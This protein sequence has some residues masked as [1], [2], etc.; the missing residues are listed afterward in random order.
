MQFEDVS[1]QD[2]PTQSASR[3]TIENE[4]PAAPYGRGSPA[5]TTR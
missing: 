5:V 4:S 3:L 1:M 2:S